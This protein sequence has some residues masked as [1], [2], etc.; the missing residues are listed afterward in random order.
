MLANFLIPIHA[1]GWR[2]I[3]IFAAIT[4]ALAWTP[5]FWPLFIATFWCVYFFRDPPRLT[6]A[7]AGLF[8]A[9][10]DGLVL[11]VEAAVPPRELGL[12]DQPMMRIS[13]FLSVFDVHINRIPTDA[14]VDVVAYHPGRFLAASD[15]K[16]GDENE[17]QSVS[18]TLA[19]G[20]K[21]VVVQIA[22][23]VARRIVCHL[24][25]GQ[26]VRAGERYGLI[27]F[28]SRTD[29]YL[30]AGVVP[31]VASGQR[32]IGGETVMADDRAADAGP[33]GAAEL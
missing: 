4:L 18:L 33:R 32:M 30:P 24:R 9:P 25:P 1:A 20:R 10:A 26:I 31:L 22:G 5:L 13:T 7:R 3:A 17:R 16:A 28:G 19:D 21:A 23:L 11:K 15:D 6:P 8:V 27:R 12:G 2:F 14:T 29:L